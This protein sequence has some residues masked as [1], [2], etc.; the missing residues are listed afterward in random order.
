MS[1]TNDNNS[2]YKQ[3]RQTN[4]RRSKR[5]HGIEHANSE[6]SDEETDEFDETEEDRG[7]SVEETTEHGHRDRLD[8]T[9]TMHMPFWDTYDA[10]NQ[11]YLQVGEL[12]IHK[13]RTF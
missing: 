1:L 13:H 12:L 10:I 7:D 3:K 6:H 5:N 2:N 8:D 9:G 4:P 11:L